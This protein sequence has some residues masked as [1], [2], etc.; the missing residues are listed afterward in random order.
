[1]AEVDHLDD[2]WTAVRDALTRCFRHYGVVP[3][4][5]LDLRRVDAL[6]P[7]RPGSNK[8]CQYWNRAR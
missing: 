5:D 1:M 2:Q 8:V 4:I 7:I 3:T 6:E